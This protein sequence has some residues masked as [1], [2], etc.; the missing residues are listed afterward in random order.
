MLDA[1]TILLDPRVQRVA[2]GGQGAEEL[3]RRPGVEA[4]PLLGL[5]QSRRQLDHPVLEGLVPA[6]APTDRDE[7]GVPDEWE[8]AHGLD[9]SVD[10]S[11]VR[12]TSGYTA[13]EDYLN[14]LARSLAAG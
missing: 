1:A 11:A 8:R 4:D 6:E 12:T 14:E 13:I 2:G 5:S 7:D 3:T 9:P 10:D